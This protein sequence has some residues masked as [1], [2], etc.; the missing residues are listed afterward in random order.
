MPTMLAQLRLALTT[1]RPSDWVVRSA[2]TG[3]FH[4]K[5]TK[6]QRHQSLRSTWS[7]WLRKNRPMEAG[8]TTITA[9]DQAAEEIG[10]GWGHN[11]RAGTAV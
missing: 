11:D 6:R 10:E 1:L 4:T 3:N 7:V 5:F 8:T 2:G 9:P